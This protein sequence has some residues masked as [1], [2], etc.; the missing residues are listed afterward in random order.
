[1]A[2]RTVL[3]T[4]ATGNLGVKLRR[5]L[6][7]LGRFEL[8]LLS[9]TADGDPAVKEADLSVYGD[10]WARRFQGAET[11][12]HLAA[13]APALSS[14]DEV[15]PHNIDA[16]LNIGHA[17]VAHG[18]KRIILASSNWVVAGHRFGEATLTPDLPPRPVNPY[19]ASKLFAERYGRHLAEHHGISVIALRIGWCQQTPG[20]RPN[21]MTRWGNWGQEMWLSDR[22]YCQI[23]EKAIEAELVGFAVL[24]A[25][26]DNP[27]ARWDLSETRRVLGYRPADGHAASPGMGTR[28]KDRVR[29][30]QSR[31]FGDASR[32]SFTDFW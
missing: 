14:W 20:N 4:G 28:L 30:V 10:R 8:R 18:V 15:V 7:S 9:L 6:E 2:K 29:G 23:M 5:H 31:L 24:N 21:S 3:I 17:A 12:V 19:G 25:M 27:G 1:M 22:D 26:S 11:V 13:S 32:I 16:V